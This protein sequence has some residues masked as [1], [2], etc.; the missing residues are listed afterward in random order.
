MQHVLEVSQETIGQVT[1]VALM[2]A[3]D[4]ANSDVFVHALQPLC[5]KGAN[6]VVDCMGLSYVNSMCFALLNKFAKD[7]AAKGGKLVYCRVPQKI[8]QI[9]QILGLHQALKL[10]STREQAIKAVS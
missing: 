5:D 10:Y 2:G 8:A 9:M 7:C 4:S 1:V 6:V 3:L